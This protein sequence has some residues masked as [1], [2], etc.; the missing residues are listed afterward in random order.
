MNEEN[1]KNQQE[2]PILPLPI[3]DSDDIKVLF[4]FL[5]K[6]DESDI[7]ASHITFHTDDF[8]DSK[9]F[10]MEEILITEIQKNPPMIFKPTISLYSK[11][12]NNSSKPNAVLNEPV[13]FSI[14]LDNP[15]HVPL[16]LSDVTLIWLFI[17]ENE[18]FTNEKISGK[19]IFKPELVDTQTIDSIVLQPTCKQN[20]VLSVTPKRLGELKILG[21]IY[22]VSNPN[23]NLTD[24]PVVNSTIT[25]EGKKL[26]EIQGRKLKII[27]AKHDTKLY[28]ADYRLEMNIVEKAPFLKVNN[29]VYR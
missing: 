25:I 27:K 12:S 16:P 7:L 11:N 18:R 19:S 5:A 4:G 1:T 15:L 8:N 10:R 23:Q 26:F 28:D 13:H 9:W 6:P 24:V 20:I 3:I 14:E 2:L 22:K 17:D 29:T 21:L